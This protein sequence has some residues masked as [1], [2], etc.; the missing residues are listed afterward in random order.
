MTGACQSSSLLEKTMS[1]TVKITKLQ[2]G[3]RFAVFH[4]YLKGDGVSPDLVN[5]ILIDPKTDFEPAKAG[6]PV[7]KL[8]KIQWSFINFQ[9]E[10]DFEYL[11]ENTPAWVL[12]NQDSNKVSFCDIGGLFDKSPPLD[13]TGKLLISTTGL[14]NTAGTILIT[15][16][17]D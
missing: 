2:D 3:P 9:A 13:G 15:I 12:N 14:T 1:H 17:K 6:K 5:T 7:I 4:I 16:R 11:S 10:L 8:N